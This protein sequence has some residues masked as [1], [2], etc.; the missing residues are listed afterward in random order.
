MPDVAEHQTQAPASPPSPPKP[1]PGGAKLRKQK[2]LKTALILLLVVAVLGGGS[3]ALY[4]FLFSSSD[5]LGE[6][7]FSEAYIGSI[8]QRASGSGTAKAKETAAI[9]L[10]AGGTVSEVFVTAGDVVTAGQPLYTIDSQE[11]QDTVAQAAQ[12]LEDLYKDMADL[13]EEA[14]NLT[15][16]AP[17]AGKLTEVQEFTV[18]QDV[19]NGTPVATL[20]NDKYLKLSLYYSYAYENSIHVG[21][22][23]SVSVPAVMGVFQ[24][25][26]DK[27]NKVSYISPEGAVFFEVV[28]SFRNPGTLTADMSASASITAADGTEIFPYENGKTQYYEV[29]E[30]QAKAGG[31]VVAIGNL[32][33]YANVSQGEPLLYLGSSDIDSRIRAKQEEID[34]AQAALDEAQNAL[35]NFNAVAPI[36]GTIITCTLTPGAE[37]KKD[38]TVIIISNTTTMLVTINVDDK[39]ISFV[40]PGSYVDLDWNGM[41]YQGLVTSVDMGNAESGN[42]MTNYPVT[43]SV[44]NFDGS[45]MDGAWLQYSFVTSESSDCVV[46]PSSAVKYISDM[47]GNRQAVV[48]VHRDTPP[49]D[50][51][52][53]A[54]PEVEPGMERTYPTTEEGYY[55]VIVET[56]LSDAEN[57][58]IKSGIE[59]GDQVFVNYTV[60]E[61][62][63]SWG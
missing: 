44:D 23:V 53:L 13:Q 20:V 18:D 38:E 27:I 10:T 46:I 12:K 9:T 17:F 11:A 15:I 34:Q 24:G 1:A 29:R 7:Y 42:G 30:I 51:P 16:T 26:V 49:D 37:V 45:L 62:G 8:Q 31:P 54:L 56:G 39:N 55:P 3:F 50:I 28:I 36:D 43:L 52:E 25:T 32:L 41:T 63:S 48:F 5:E 58:E 14:N 2:Q 6:I 47:D 60:T 61:M 22:S 4:R 59:P 33:N 57:A 19:A 35:N 40:K 21:Q